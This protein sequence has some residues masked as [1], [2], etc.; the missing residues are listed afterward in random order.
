MRLSTIAITIVAALAAAQA[1]ARGVGISSDPYRIYATATAGSL[2]KS[3]S[4]RDWA[5]ASQL[6]GTDNDGHYATHE[7][8]ALLRKGNAGCSDRS[9]TG[10]R[11]DVGACGRAGIGL[12]HAFGMRRS[13]RGTSSARTG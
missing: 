13:Q 5:L 9:S 10:A 1:S 3:K 4:P 8:A 2:E 12:R 6:L 11:S 7:R